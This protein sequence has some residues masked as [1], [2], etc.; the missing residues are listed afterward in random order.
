VWCAEQLSDDNRRFLAELPF[1]DALSVDAIGDVRFVHA[2]ARSDEEIVTERT[3]LDR[4]REAFAPCSE[5]VVVC[6]HTH[7]Q[8]DLMV[9]DRRVI[10]AGSVGMPFEPPGAYWLELGET[11]RLRRTGFDIAAAAKRIRETSYPEA[12]E[13]AAN[14]VEQTP[15][16]ATMLAMFDR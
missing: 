3:P 11:V 8:F 16:K 1:S 7:M 12:A 10:N 9:D 2:T 4:M 15:D 14:N 5:R 6:G 13:F